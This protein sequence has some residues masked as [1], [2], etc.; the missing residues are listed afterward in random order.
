MTVRF[1]IG[2]AGSGKTQ[3]CVEALVR[4]AKTP[5]GPPL[6]WLVPEQAAFISERRLMAHPDMT[7]TFRIRVTGFRRLC[8][9]LAQQFAIPAEM[10][11]KSAERILL[12]SEAVRPCVKKLRIYGDSAQKPGF[13][14]TLDRT[15]RELV[16]NNQTPE[17]LIRLSKLEEGSSAN[18]MLA[19]KLADLAL[20]LQSWR[21]ITEKDHPDPEL[22]P[23][24]VAQKLLTQPPLAG[25]AVWV[26]A[27]SSMSLV[28]MQLCASLAK[29]VANMEITL[30]ADSESPAMKDLSAS[31]DELS[32]FYRTER[33]YQQLHNILK[34]NGVTIE[35]PLKLVPN[36]RTSSTPALTRIERHLFSQTGNPAPGTLG[37]ADEQIQPIQLWHCRDPEGEVHAAGRWIRD[38]IANGGRYCDTGV[39]VG[40]LEAYEEPVRRIF[41]ALNISFFL[42]SR[43]A[44]NHHPLVLFLNTA[45]ALPENNFARSDWLAL[46]KTGLAG[47]DAGAA[48]LLEN[49]LLAHGIDE[50]DFSAAWNWSRT[51]EDPDADEPTEDQTAL[52]ATAN[53]LREK[54]YQDFAPWLGLARKKEPSDGAALAQALIDLLDRLGVAKTLQQWIAGAQNPQVYHAGNGPELAQMHQQIWTQT[55]ELLAAMHRIFTGQKITP[56]HFSE[57]LTLGLGT[58]TLGLIPPAVD[59]VLISSTERSRHPELKTVIILGALEGLM[60]RIRRDESMLDDDDRRQ[61]LQSAGAADG[62]FD[63]PSDQNFLQRTFFDYVAFTRAAKELIVSVPLADAAGRK[64]VPS[65]H[66][67]RLCEL[68]PDLKPLDQTQSQ[69]TITAAASVEELVRAV[70]LEA[71]HGA[72]PEDS[73]NKSRLMAAYDWLKKQSD[74]QILTAM[75]QAWSGFIDRTPAQLPADLVR[76]ITKK[77]KSVSEL[78]TLAACPLQWFFRYGLGLTKRSELTMDRSDLGDLYHRTLRVFF[79]QIMRRRLNWPD[80]TDEQLNHTLE[81]ALAECGKI[82]R[83]ELAQQAPETSVVL[84]NMRRNLREL[85]KFHRDFARHNH[86]RPVALELGFGAIFQPHSQPDS[87]AATLP[88]YFLTLADGA[89]VEL[90]GK[91]DRV[92]ADANGAAMVIDYKLT[93]KTFQAVDLEAGLTLQLMTYL[94]AIAGQ[95]PTEQIKPLQSIGA[96]YQVLAPYFQLDKSRS[97]KMRGLF[98]D[99]HY[100]CIDPID[101]SQ[102]SSFV[103]L[104]RKKD[105]EFSRKGHD[106]ITHP[107]FEAVSKFTHDKLAKLAVLSLSGQIAPRPY[108]KG[109]ATPCTNCDYQSACPFDRLRGHYR[110]IETDNQGAL[111][112]ITQASEGTT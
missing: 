99:T 90:R 95:T 26:D 62:G 3:H 22:F 38:K 65:I 91:I 57:L 31:P 59:Q 85:V 14:T 72:W 83:Q 102:A 110:K 74:A 1:I 80:C 10:E 92:D 7:G 73:E 8:R 105:G 93:G 19:A 30:L 43:R 29:S 37:A 103:N 61:L 9:I 52:L 89:S 69:F 98:D 35:N 6:F 77:Q 53:A 111:V 39:I 97:Y 28:E 101:A 68:F 34:Q 24:L 2:R 42:D 63:L 44:V 51:F 60:P 27:F 82:V 66:I 13:L 108:R 112:R 46:I 45:I 55:G 86:L 48:S 11:L 16:Q 106:G 47:V 56:R 64:T 109:S 17:S 67:T 49:Y 54:L 96:F 41:S 36:H 76:V 12:L 107:G 79:G 70:A 25:T 32:I 21:Q 18:P 40:D 4:A 84:E 78:E 50:D 33:L 100:L 20:L 15:L 104:I 75:R 23:Q 5:V 87:N 94:L 71:G 88:A 81:A 58:L